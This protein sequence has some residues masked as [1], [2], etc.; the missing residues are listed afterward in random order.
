MYIT[1]L[2]KN[3]VFQCIGI[4]IEKC[5]KQLSQKYKGISLISLFILKDLSN[6]NIRV[7]VIYCK[8]GKSKLTTCFVLS[9]CMLRLH[10]TTEM[11]HYTH[12]AS[13]DKKEV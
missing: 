6:I 13:K 5:F 9:G 3:N 11:L 12:Y 8:Q 2:I 1:L 7:L 10:C 4:V